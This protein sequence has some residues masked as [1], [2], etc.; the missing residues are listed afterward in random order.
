MT[1][2]LCCA[3]SLS[4]VRLCDP[5]D[6]SPPGS[7]VHGIL[8]ARTLEWVA[9]SCP[10]PGDLPNPGIKPRPPAW[11][12]DSSPSEPPR[13]PKNPGVGSLSL[14]Q[15]IFLIQE[16]NWGLLHCSRILYQLSHQGSPVMPF[17]QD[18]TSEHFPVHCIDCMQATKKSDQALVITS[19]LWLQAFM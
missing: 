7:S 17:S 13:K 6:C 18:L 14:P 5:V 12:E 16:S 1:S 15:G 9:L 11:Q 8:Q 10:P 3:Y 19:T 4:R 2:V